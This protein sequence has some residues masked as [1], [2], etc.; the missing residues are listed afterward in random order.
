MQDSGLLPYLPFTFAAVLGVFAAWLGRNGWKWATLTFFVCFVAFFVAATPL[1]EAELGALRALP[2]LAVFLIVWLARRV[3]F[4]R[5]PQTEL[6]RKGGTLILAGLTA[7]VFT[8]AVFAP[9]LLELRTIASVRDEVYLADAVASQAFD[10]E[11]RTKGAVST[12]DAERFLDGDF[13]KRYDLTLRDYEDREGHFAPNGS[14]WNSWP[15]QTRIAFVAWITS[16]DGRLSTWE[17]RS[18][19]RKV[20]AFYADNNKAQFVVDLISAI[21]EDARYTRCTKR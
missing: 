3:I 17:I 9:V 11:L 14:H 10:R 5:K 8:A 18:I 1:A 21:Q 4:R 7:A 15:E 16:A 6:A 12:Q 13:L 19:I 2:A 20:D